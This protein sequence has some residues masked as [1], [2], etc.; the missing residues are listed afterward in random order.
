MKNQFLASLHKEWMFF[1]RTKRL[2]IYT[3]IAF[4]F[5]VIHI[6]GQYFFRINFVANLLGFATS[7]ITWILS[8]TTFNIFI[9]G[10]YLSFVLFMTRNAVTRELKEKNLST[11]LIL[12]LKPEANLGAKFIIQALIPSIIAGIFSMINAVI[13][14]LLFEQNSI[15]VINTTY[16][17]NFSDLASSAYA[18]SMVFL[19]YLVALIAIEVFTKRSI[20]SLVLVL[21]FYVCSES[22][23]KVSN[24]LKFTPVVFFDYATTLVSDVSKSQIF[25]SFAVTIALIILLIVTSMLVYSDRSDYKL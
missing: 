2:S 3:L 12:G 23:F 5:L 13:S 4:I 14:I 1:T 22:I 25:L 10:L 7:E 8:Q 9:L 6:T 20:L 24:L 21:I 11:P 17:V 19:L 15:S 16:I 18:V